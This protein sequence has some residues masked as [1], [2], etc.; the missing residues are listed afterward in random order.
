MLKAC[1]NGRSVA[2]TVSSFTRYGNWKKAGKPAYSDLR[3]GDVI[4]S[5]SHVM[6]YIGD[7][8]VV[9]AGAE[10]WGPDSICIDNLSPGYYKSYDF[11]MRYT[12]TGSG[13]MYVI[14]YVDD[15][16]N[17]IEDQEPAEEA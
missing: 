2:M 15:D 12:G 7:G 4:V 9:H 13:T 1:K 3:R 14:K 8:Q 10:G 11:V 6:L 5:N 17:V 16:G